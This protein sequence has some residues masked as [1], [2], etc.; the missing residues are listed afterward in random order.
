MSQATREAV[1]DK[2]SQFYRTLPFNYDQT[3]EQAARTIRAERDAY[4]AASDEHQRQAAEQ[5]AFARYRA[6]HTSLTDE[7]MLR[8]WFRDQVLHP[9]ESQHTF[10]EL[11]EWLHLAGFTCLATSL[12]KFQPL[13]DWRALF[14]DEKR[15]SEISYQR[16]VKERRYFPGFFVVLAKQREAR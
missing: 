5:R 10:Q 16:N 3:V 12:N 8:S 9:H 15:F 6:L 1:R 13:R 7:V 2:V 14:E 11:Y 4:E